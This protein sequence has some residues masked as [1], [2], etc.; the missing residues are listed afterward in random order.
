[1]EA[2]IFRPRKAAADGFL[3]GVVFG[4]SAAL[5]VVCLILVLRPTLPADL[6]AATLGLAGMMA[7]LAV[8]ET[9]L[10]KRVASSI[11]PRVESH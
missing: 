10:L 8:K 9:G 2:R 7:L 5:I 1:L 6:F 4:L 11:R 3:L